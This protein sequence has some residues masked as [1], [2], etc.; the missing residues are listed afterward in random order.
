MEVVQI[1]PVTKT[2]LLSRPKCMMSQ[3]DSNMPTAE[4]G[5]NRYV[6]LV[7]VSERSSLYNAA[8]QSD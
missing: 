5:V 7:R 8:I 3:A 6:K 1:I 4:Q 2:T